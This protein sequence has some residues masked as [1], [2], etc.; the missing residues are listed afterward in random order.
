MT[1]KVRVAP[2]GL[3]CFIH[4]DMPMHTLPRTTALCL[5]APL[6]LAACAAP[7]TDEIPETRVQRQMIGLLEK[8][9]RWDYNGDGR[10]TANE[11]GEAT[12]LSGVPA[13]DIIKFYDTDGDGGIT[14]REA[15][16]GYSRPVQHSR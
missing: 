13:A 12:K 7:H 6:L 1:G 4:A 8:F 2:G 15:Q 3:P 5:A 10:L 16:A 14:L 9:D 11:L